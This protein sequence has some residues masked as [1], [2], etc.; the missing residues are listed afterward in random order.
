MLCNRLRRSA[1]YTSKIWNIRCFTTEYILGA[2]RNE[3]ERLKLSHQFIK[4]LMM[5]ALEKTSISVNTNNINIL[6][7]GFGAGCT[8][9]ELYN[10]F[11]SNAKK[12]ISHESPPNIS[13]DAV[14]SNPKWHEY[15]ESNYS[16]LIKNNIY[17]LH[18][19]DILNE[20]QL[21]NTFHANDKKF[22][23]IFVRFVMLHIHPS[24]TRN[25]IINLF[26]LLKTGGNII[27]QEPLCDSN[28][29]IKCYPRNDIIETYS[30]KIFDNLIKSNHFNPISP[31]EILSILNEYN[32]NI[33]DIDSMIYGGL[34]GD[35]GFECT[36]LGKQSFIN[37][38]YKQ[39]VISLEEK[40]EVIQSII[41]L[42][43]QPLSY[44]LGGP[45][46][47]IIGQYNP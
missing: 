24:N 38:L 42:Q 20:E 37:G 46:I 39:G 31:I 7:V 1:T 12:H 27:F 32:M 36:L 9:H 5:R 43:Q 11:S 23:V 28:L 44:V 13:I 3:L 47:S 16:S 2:N 4:P 18:N 34:N 21:T 33:I 17:R 41:N 30:A 35:P 40:D 14:D 22:D 26:K 8:T 29:S 25:A 6:D 19:V 10:Y 15:M 45:L